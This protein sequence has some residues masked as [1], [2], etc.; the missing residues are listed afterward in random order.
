MITVH[1]FTTTP[2][3]GSFPYGR[4]TQ[5]SDGFLYG[6][7]AE[8]GVENLGAVYRLDSATGMVTTIHSFTTTAP[9]SWG[10][11]AGLTQASNGFLYGTTLGGGGAMGLSSSGTVYRL[12]PATGEVTTL[13]SFTWM[14]PGKPINPSP[15]AGLTQAGD[16]FLYGT[17]AYGGAF[18][19]GSIYR[20]EPVTDEVS[21][22]YSFTIGQDG[23]VP[24]AALMEARDGFLY[25]TTEQGGTANA[26][27][28]YRLDPATGA[29]TTVHSFPGT[30]PG[31]GSPLA[32][33]TQAAAGFLYGATSGQSTPA[34]GNRLPAQSHERRRDD[35]PG[36]HGRSTGWPI[37]DSGTN[38]GQRRLSLRHNRTRRCGLSR[39]HLST[40]P[41]DEYH[42]DGLLLHRGPGRWESVCRADA[43][44][45]RVPLR[46]RLSTACPSCRA[47]WRVS[48]RSIAST[49]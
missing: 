1:S 7:T 22:V 5:G 25:G 9:S 45:R 39:H 12:H 35:H 46:D 38:P 11:H 28:V 10:P 6:T 8:G 15:Y 34:G 29:V 4:L 20:L 43:G 14:G 36:V 40:R 48:A 41:G 19:T 2:P 32:G 16:G 47:S 24:F 44:Q 49:R 42:D 31:G 37:P 17:T 33:L 18:G 3:S 30:A 13:H 27:T 26:G 23:R 21:T